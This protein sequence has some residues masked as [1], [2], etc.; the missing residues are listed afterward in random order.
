[1]LRM[2]CG[3]LSKV[4]QMTLF[5]TPMSALSE[6]E[7]AEVDRVM[8]GIG[9]TTDEEEK[10]LAEYGDEDPNVSCKYC[11][12]DHHTAKCPYIQKY[13]IDD[14]GKERVLTLAGLNLCVDSYTIQKEEI[15]EDN[16][17]YEQS[18]PKPNVTIGKNHVIRGDIV[19]PNDPHKESYDCRTGMV[20][21]CRCPQP[22]TLHCDTC[23]VTRSVVTKQWRLI[24]PEKGIMGRKNKKGKGKEQRPKNQNKSGKKDK[25]KES[26]GKP[27]SSTSTSIATKTNTTKTIGKGGTLSKNGYTT[28]AKDRHYG[29]KYV[30]MKGNVTIYVSS[31]WNNRKPDEFTPDF[32][33]YFDWG[34][35]P[36]WRNEHVD[37]PD[38]NIPYNQEI[39]LE[40]I[41]DALNRAKSGVKVE[42]GCIG[43]HGRTGT[44]LAVM[45][46]LLG[47]DHKEAVEHVRQNHCGHAIENKKQEWW[48]E[49]VWCKLH[50][51]KPPEMPKVEPKSYSYGGSTYGSG[52]STGG[53]SAGG[54]YG[55]G[56]HSCMIADHFI[57]WVDQGA[58]LDSKCSKKGDKCTFWA[59][60]TDKFMKGDYPTFAPSSKTS[61][62][63]RTK[64]V[65][66]FSVPEPPSGVPGHDYSRAKGGSCGKCDVCRYIDRYGMG[67]F[68]KP[69]D[70]TKGNQ[71]EKDMDV[72]ANYARERR[73]DEIR[74]QIAVLKMQQITSDNELDSDN[75][76]ATVPQTDLVLPQ[77]PIP[78]GA[79]GSGP[80][81][82][83]TKTPPKTETILVATSD[84]S[85]KEAEITESFPSRP[86]HNDD[87][88]PLHNER[89][90]DYIYKEG[91]GWVWDQIVQQPAGLG[92]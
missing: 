6:D 91:R 82:T 77:H 53:Y 62:P 84:G 48:V 74:A 55:S 85:I 28:A 57:D 20:A 78:V 47:A 51:K 23:N 17:E 39:A 36:Y 80:T 13:W 21:K 31:M 12:H 49:W 59:Q 68:L 4:Y 50:D 7:K 1:M 75:K 46:V 24:H 66:G 58:V 60:D 72:I 71:W 61:L 52:Y 37:W 3:M 45:N 25:K 26:K 73:A 5:N 88:K 67:A 86:P 90:G 14:E 35:K 19:I 27:A 44:A 18:D 29:D 9:T 64:V 43:A 41:K 89:R 69:I 2:L 42:V 83:L 70:V 92:L 30:T 76:P 33:L 11:Y 15:Q 16:W 81:T 34:W 63:V 38:F 40:Q 22:K 56:G 10:L 8:S 32:G 87:K 79:P 54:S 65:R